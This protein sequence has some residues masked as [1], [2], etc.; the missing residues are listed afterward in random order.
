M[1]EMSGSELH[2]VP[3]GAGLNIPTIIIT[4]N[5]DLGCR[6]RFRG[7]GAEY[8]LKPLDHVKLISAINKAIGRASPAVI[9]WSGTGEQG[10]A[11]SR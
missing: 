6:E 4:A 2:C 11:S 1:P 9:P 3:M 5:D 7:T 10:G 8:L